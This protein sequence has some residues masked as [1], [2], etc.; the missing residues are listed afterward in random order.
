MKYICYLITSLFICISAFAQNEPAHLI[1]KLKNAKSESQKISAYNELYSYYQYA[2]PDSATCYLNEGLKQFTETKYKPGIARMT[3]LLASEDEIHGRMTLAKRR[4]DEA[5][6]LYREL[7]D[8]DGIANVNNGLGVIDGRNGNYEGATRHFMEAL[9]LFEGISDK[10]GIIS[11]YLKLGVV[12]E[13]SNNLDKALEYYNKAMAMTKG[14]SLS[15]NVVF[16]YNN[17]AIVYGKKGDYKKAL[18]YLQIALDKADKPEFTGVRVRSLTNMGIVYDH[19][20]DD[21]KALKYFNEALQITKDKNLPEE[22]A[23]AIVNMSSVIGKT[24]PAKAIANLKEALVMAKQ[25]HQRALQLEIYDNL[26]KDYKKT[27]NYKEAMETL[28][29]QEDLQDSLNS[30]DKAKEVANIEAEL[31]LEATNAKMQQLEILGHK[32]LLQRNIIIMV[33]VVMAVTLIILA[34]FLRKITH[35]NEQLFKRETELRNSNT[36]KDKL[37]SIIGH[38]LRGPVGNIPIMLQILQDQSTTPT[39][40]KYIFETLIEHSQASLE[41]LDKLLYWGQAQIK[42]IGLKP[43]DFNPGKYLQ[44]SLQL[45]K[46]NADQKQ[47]NITNNVPGDIHIHGD[48]AHFD[49]II[50]NLLSNAVKFTNISGCVSITADK[51][52]TTGFT[53]FTIKDNGIGISKERIA[54]IFEPF[55]NSTGGTADERGTSIGLMLCKEFVI[56]NGGKIWVE[57]EP[58]KGSTFHFSFKTT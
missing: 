39:E 30:N 4:Y 6:D 54:E 56:Q 58:G 17:I 19:F 57:S 3:S 7:N 16:L 49:F 47:I 36:V 11:T 27:G 26:V 40:Q 32:N 24:D 28:E 43:I 2:N 20:G 1:A 42:G 53:I 15:P 29:L 33:A 23:R 21:E 31:E 13:L 10:A 45:I 35:L 12:N 14:D 38:D 55:S 5:L 9:K 34:W 44:N 37:F 18:E 22:H 52:S 25:L 46:S 41:T 48:P 50:R 51:N 8:K